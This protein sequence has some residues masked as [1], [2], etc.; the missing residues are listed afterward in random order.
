MTAV[1]AMTMR[2]KVEYVEDQIKLKLFRSDSGTCKFSYFPFQLRDCDLSGLYNGA[3]PV[4]PTKLAYAEYNLVRFSKAHPGNLKVLTDLAAVYY[5]KENLQ[6][7]FFYASAAVQAGLDCLKSSHFS[8]KREK[9]DGSCREN[10]P[11]LLAFLFAGA[12]KTEWRDTA[13]AV[14]FFERALQIDP[15]DSCGARGFA[16][17]ACL[18]LDRPDKAFK[19]WEKYS[20]P[21]DLLLEILY[22]MPIVHLKLGN[23]AKADQAVKR[24][25]DADPKPAIQLL[26][27]KNSEI[28][29]PE[30]SL[31]PSVK[32]AAAH[33]RRVMRNIWLAT[34]GAMDLLRRHAF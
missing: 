1:S 16:M 9:L 7:S 10:R 34:D 21:D 33:Y 8:S 5:R 28:G 20:R 32:K 24:A 11:L 19:I 26:R 29:C 31:Y 23:R 2:K 4:S 12:I 17:N 6:K 30:R 25:V 27:V 18:H 3:T 14:N 15:D 22:G 13:G